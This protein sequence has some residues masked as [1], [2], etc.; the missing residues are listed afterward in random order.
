MALFKRGRGRFSIGVRNEEFPNAVSNCH[1]VT[2][3][4]QIFKGMKV[5][6]R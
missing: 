4:L 3:D 6:N 5:E 2:P 1:H